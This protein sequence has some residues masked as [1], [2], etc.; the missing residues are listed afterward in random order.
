MLLL[1]LL[2]VFFSQLSDSYYVLSLYNFSHI[3]DIAKYLIPLCSCTYLFSGSGRQQL[4][5][6]AFQ[7]QTPQMNVSV[8]ANLNPENDTSSVQSENLNLH[9]NEDSTLPESDSSDSDFEYM[10]KPPSKRNSRKIKNQKLRKN[11]RKL[12]G[13]SPVSKPPKNQTLKN[14]KKQEKVTEESQSSVPN[15]LANHKRRASYQEISELKIG[16]KVQS[17]SQLSIRKKASCS[18]IGKKK[19]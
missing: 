17:K 5:E 14:S 16:R 4:K 18:S 3:L 7:L 1:F 10:M 2:T 15:D 19:S 13:K 12:D 9:S 8:V 6:K 11:K